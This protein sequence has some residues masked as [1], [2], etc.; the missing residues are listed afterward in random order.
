[1]IYNYDDT[2]LHTVETG[3]VE[4]T[5]HIGLRN[6]AMDLPSSLPAVANGDALLLCLTPQLARA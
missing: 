6:A 3:N 1:M 5:T 4:H 2:V